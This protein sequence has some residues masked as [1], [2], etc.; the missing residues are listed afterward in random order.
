MDG[1]Q[2]IVGKHCFRQWSLFTL[3]KLSGSVF[4]DNLGLSV[5]VSLSDYFVCFCVEL[6]K[7]CAS[8]WVSVDVGTWSSV[9]DWEGHDCRR[10]APTIVKAAV[11]LVSGY[12]EKIY[13]L[14]ASGNSE[15]SWVISLSLS[16]T[17]THTPYP[18]QL[19]HPANGNEVM[20]SGYHLGCFSL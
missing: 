5:I 6:L 20:C 4:L 16:L 13:Y 10:L 11:S 15:P 2:F 17:H 12:K 8:F 3:L 19:T 9:G 1:S 7:V 14:S 18:F